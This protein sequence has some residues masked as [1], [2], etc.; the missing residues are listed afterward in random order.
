MGLPLFATG[1]LNAG[2]YSLFLRAVS[3]AASKLPP[4]FSYFAAQSGFLF[5]VT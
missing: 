3:A 2:M 4:V 1:R 5:L